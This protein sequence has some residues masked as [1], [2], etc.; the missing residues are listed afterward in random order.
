MGSVESGAERLRPQQ[1]PALHVETFCTGSGGLECNR[2]SIKTFCIILHHRRLGALDIRDAKATMGFILKPFMITGFRKFAGLVLAFAVLT[3]TSTH[4]ATVQVG[5]AKVDLT[6]PIGGTTTGY[7]SAPTTDG[8]HDPVEARVLVLKSAE[9]TVALVSWDLCIF[10]SP[11][12]HARREALGLD[13]LLLS[14]THTHAG[15]NLREESFPSPDNPWRVTVEQRTYE[16]IESALSNL[17][18]AT[19]AAGIGEIPLGYNRLVRQ[20]GGYA[21]TYFNNPERI[22]YGPIDPTVNVLRINDDSG[23]TRVVLVNTACHPVVLGPR[24]RKISAGF[25]GVMR[26]RVEESLGGDVM[27]F[28]FQGGAGD[29]NPLIMA[30][31]SETREDDFELVRVLG[32][33]LAD[34]ALVVLTEI[35]D[36]A[37][38]GNRLRAASSVMSVAHRFNEQEVLNVGVASVLLN[39]DIGIVT[40]PGEP[41]HKF[42]RDLRDLAELP[43]MFFFGYTCNDAYAWPSYLPDV[44]SAAYGGYGASDTTRVEV[45][46]GERLLHQGVAQLYRMQR[47]LKAKPV[48]QVNSE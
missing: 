24:N 41:F 33:L 29:V 9:T 18:E 8:V 34:E 20:S 37:G 45:G 40:M 7:S 22:P 12:L 32:D 1:A 38:T 14:N 44:K 5:V 11:W 6:P 35:S 15:P 27:A 16:A 26:R 43:F 48:R 30:R 42:Q 47:R 25:P 17:F 2:F 10:N 39:D 4:A 23:A 3:G 19:F 36:T 13:V 31:D 21:A 28:F 46:T